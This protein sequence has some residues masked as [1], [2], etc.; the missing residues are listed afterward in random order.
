[1]KVGIFLTNQQ[2]LNSDMVRALGDQIA[3]IEN[4]GG[5]AAKRDRKGLRRVQSDE[6]LVDQ[7]TGSEGR[8]RAQ[9][10]MTRIVHL[11]IHAVRERFDVSGTRYY[12]LL[13]ELIGSEDAVEYNPMVVRRL[14]RMRERR[15]RARYEGSSPGES[16]AR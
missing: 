3:G 4:T 1:M 14:R 15:R 8:R 9:F 13:G 5:R 2:H 12:Q 16:P 6:G 7:N 10:H 11:R